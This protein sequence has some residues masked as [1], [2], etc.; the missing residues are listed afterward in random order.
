MNVEK[1]EKKELTELK[2]ENQVLSTISESVYAAMISE[3][4]LNKL[5]I[6]LHK[7]NFNQ[8]EI[9]ALNGVS[10][11]TIRQ[12]SKGGLPVQVLGEKTL[13]YDKNEVNEWI[14]KH[15]I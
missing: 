13:L 7:E 11:V 3:E 2:L 9:A 5:M 15:K 10:P 8:G 4:F 1:E 6:I 14:K 12:W